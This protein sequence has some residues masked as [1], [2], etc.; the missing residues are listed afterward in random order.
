M[1]QARKDSDFD[2]GVGHTIQGPSVG[3]ALGG[4]VKQRKN[5]QELGGLW[6]EFTPTLEQQLLLETS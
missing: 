4:S 5:C 1:T 3:F 2:L 6:E